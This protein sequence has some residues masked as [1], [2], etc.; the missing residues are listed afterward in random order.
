[1]TKKI[2]GNNS[3]NNIFMI[4][5][6]IIIL[7]NMILLMN[8]TV[9]T[10]HTTINMDMTNMAMKW[11]MMIIIVATTPA[12]REQINTMWLLV[13]TEIAVI[14]GGI[15]LDLIHGKDSTMIMIDH[16]QKFI[17]KTSVKSLYLN[18]YHR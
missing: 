15:Q 17:Y 9:T 5:M 10:T 1:M 16:C 3:I 14:L 12:I 7:F 11:I 2:G 6:F 8:M 13:S 4:K 18:K